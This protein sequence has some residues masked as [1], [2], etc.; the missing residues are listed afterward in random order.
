MILDILEIIYVCGFLIYY[1]TTWRFDGIGFHWQGILLA[2]IWF[3]VL[4]ID[5][6]NATH[7]KA[8]L[9]TKIFRRGG[10]K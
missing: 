1:V 7:N 6:Y 3:I 9:D 2:P 10:C 5:W 8:P 4:P